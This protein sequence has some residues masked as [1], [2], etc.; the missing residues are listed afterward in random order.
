MP[1]VRELKIGHSP[2]C[3][4]FDL[5][6]FGLWRRPKWQKKMQPLDTYVGQIAL[7]QKIACMYAIRF[8]IQ[9][10]K[11]DTLSQVKFWSQIH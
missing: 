11:N 6:I 4:S 10:I 8:G 5:A 3:F 9:H 1:F 7:K 2:H